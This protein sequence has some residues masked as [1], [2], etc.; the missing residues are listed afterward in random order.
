VPGFD[1][2]FFDSAVVTLAQ[3]PLDDES[4]LSLKVFSEYAQK[5]LAPE[6]MHSP[7][8]ARGSRLF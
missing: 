1:P 6:S 5:L 3:A 8:I 7:E 4:G 2:T